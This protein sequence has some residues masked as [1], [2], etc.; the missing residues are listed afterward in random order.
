MEDGWEYKKGVGRKRDE[1]GAAA[2]VK[3]RQKGYCY[4]NVSV[5]HNNLVHV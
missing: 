2:A 3:E 5:Q 4:Y 1:S